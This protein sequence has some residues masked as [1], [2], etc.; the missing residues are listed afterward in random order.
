MSE[1]GAASAPAQT[2]SMEEAGNKLYERGFTTDGG[3]YHQ[4]GY[5]FTQYYQG[6]EYDSGGNEQ[7]INK[8]A[9][10]IL[11]NPSTR[12]TIV[13]D[14]DGKELERFTLH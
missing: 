13:S 6:V 2:L 3:A 5:L 9:G 10:T 8:L 4:G 7:M 11:V 1:F 14:S 12:E